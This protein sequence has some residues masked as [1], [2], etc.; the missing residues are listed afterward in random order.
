MY[1]ARLWSRRV[2][3]EICVGAMPAAFAR[4][5][6]F[7]FA[8]LPTTTARTVLFAFASAEPCALKMPTFLLITSFR[9]IPSLRGKAPRKMA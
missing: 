1:V 8:G 3:A 9:S 5:A 2:S 6:A 4:I 7:V